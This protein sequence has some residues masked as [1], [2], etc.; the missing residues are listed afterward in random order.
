MTNTDNCARWKTPNDNEGPG[1]EVVTTR[2]VGQGS[3]GED[4]N[5]ANIDNGANINPLHGSFGMR[6]PVRRGAGRGQLEGGDVGGEV[7]EPLHHVVEAVIAEEVQQ[8]EGVG[9]VTL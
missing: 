7:V 6:M 9:R 8:K 5:V 1:R 4:G 2:G 3:I